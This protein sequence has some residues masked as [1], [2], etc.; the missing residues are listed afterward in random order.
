MKKILLLAL[1]IPSFLYASPWVNAD[2]TRLRLTI[3]SLSL[4]GVN[5]PN[6]NKFPYNLSNVYNEIENI[7]LS[8]QSKKC[9][10]IIL[11]LEEF[12]R[13][14]VSKETIRIGLQ[15]RGAE[16]KLTD[17]SRRQIKE[18]N[19][20]FFIEKTSDNWSIKING[21]KIYK[22]DSIVNR[23][24]ESYIAYTF[25][26][27][28]IKLG[29]TSRWWSP[30]WDTSLILSNNARPIPSITFSN[31]LANSVKLPF[32]ELLGPLN[33]EFFVGQLEKDRK[34]S[35]AKMLGTR[36][37]FN[38]KPK[39]SMSLFRTAQFG[40]EGRPENLK[41]IVK[42]ILGQDNV[43]YSGITSVN[44]PGNQLA[45][46]DFKIK[47]L[48]KNN[49]EF[50]SQIVGEDKGEQFIV[51]TKTFYNFGIG[52]FFP[53][54]KYIDKLLL[55]Y[56][57][58]KAYIKKKR[59]VFKNITYNHEVYEDGYRYYKKPIGSS[60]DA[61][62]AKLSF[63]YLRQFQKNNLLKIKYTTAKINKNFSLKNYWGSEPREKKALELSYS[64]QLT[65]RFDLF[66]EYGIFEDNL[67]DKKIN[68]QNLLVRIEYLVL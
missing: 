40:G 23:L 59:G 57:N 41:T 54:T 50:F 56:T 49:L 26:N 58:T 7:D 21:T 10:E 32:V 67:V 45:G 48:E 16:Q 64:T 20:Y 24:D 46:I 28:I 33:Y 55:E 61:D 44:Q 13:V 63:I 11:S 30:S 6:L 12:I 17:F 36:I 19:A 18:E 68:D 2:D 9:R 22:E 8:N 51:P 37:S 27:K 29:R 31:N 60:I 39:F 4:C 5:P 65:K 47:A 43:G 38:P 15:S 53:N 34:I 35:K 52:Y 25:N 14:S 66:F 1:T 3:E 62:S 42:L